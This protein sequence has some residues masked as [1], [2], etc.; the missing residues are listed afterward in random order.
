MEGRYLAPVMD[1]V[2]KHTLAHLWL[3]AQHRTVSNSLIDKEDKKLPSNEKG[4]ALAQILY[5]QT[6]GSSF[7]CPL[8]YLRITMNRT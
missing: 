2:R 4:E 8:L 5:A 6:R 3:F 1:D 7:S